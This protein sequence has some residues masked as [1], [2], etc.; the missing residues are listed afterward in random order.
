MAGAVRHARVSVVIPCYNAGEY[1]EEA[2]QS[3]LAQTYRDVEVIVVD[4]GSTDARTKEILDGAN[5]P[6]TTIIRQANGGPSAAR[7][8]AISAASGEF[9]LPLDADDRIS[10]AYIEKAVAV[11]QARPEVGIV[12][13]K[14]H[15]FGVE[16]GA[17]QLPAYTLNELVIDNVIFCT[18]LYRKEDWSRVGGY[19]ESLRHGMEDYEFWIKLVHLG[20]A[21]H[22]IDEPLFFYRIQ[23]NS[24][25]TGFMANNRKVV[26]TYAD[27]FRA[28][29]DFFADNAEILF[30]HRFQLYDE[31][32]RYR[33]RYGRIERLLERHRWLK[34][35][36]RALFRAA[37]SLNSLR[38]RV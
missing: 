12:Y 3:A 22:Q 38:K 4:D 9:I 5:W 6:N 25:T 34:K 14:A 13:C 24:R 23:Q 10:P 36:A 17:W 19:N 32:N 11:M 21:V 18:S 15:K 35:I 28:N 26:S 7:N 37:H 8:R 29:K 30:E 33:R 16:K 31:L 20:C 2:V 27:I 1:L